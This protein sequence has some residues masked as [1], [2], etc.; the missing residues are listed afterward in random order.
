[1]GLQASVD[2][3]ATVAVR[4]QLVFQVVVDL[5]VL[6]DARVVVALAALKVDLVCR[7]LPVPQAVQVFEAT[8]AFPEN[9]E[10]RACE[11]HLVYQARRVPQE[12][13]A[14]LAIRAGT[15][16]PAPEAFRVH[17]ATLAG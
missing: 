1:M 7:A 3:R 4:A 8:T 10:I 17:K 2:S 5:V 11:D 15:L 13:Q 12:L 14:R 9:Q 16:Y 6:W